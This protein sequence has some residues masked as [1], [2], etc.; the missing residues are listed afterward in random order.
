MNFSLNSPSSEN[1]NQNG[2]ATGPNHEV[3]VTNREMV[4]TTS[5]PDQAPGPPNP[6]A[7]AIRPL[8]PMAAPLPEL[9]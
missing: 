9:K 1:K 4:T 5:V 2:T 6:R 8:R 7:I 3:A